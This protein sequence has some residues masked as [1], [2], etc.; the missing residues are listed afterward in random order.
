[1]FLPNTRLLCCSLYACNGEEGRDDSTGPAK[2][3]FGQTQYIINDN[4][5]TAGYIGAWARGGRGRR[6]STCRKKRWEEG[7]ACALLRGDVGDLIAES[8]PKILR[9]SYPS[10]GPIYPEQPSMRRFAF[11]TSPSRTGSRTFFQ[12]VAH[13]D[14]P[15][16][17]RKRA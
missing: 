13:G 10:P 12:Q 15:H 16:P 1:M 6:W 8:L 14:R 9:G 7:R 5:I 17:E 3:K 4:A 11:V 2:W